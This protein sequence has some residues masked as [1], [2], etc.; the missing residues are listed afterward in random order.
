MFQNYLKV[1]WRNLTK[2]KV[3]FVINTLGLATGMAACGLILLY[4]T[5]ERSYDDFHPDIERTY[6]IELDSY[7][8]GKLAWRSATSYPAIAPTLQKDFPEVETTA[9]LYDAD[10]S[11]V[12]YENRRF[13]EA[14]FYFADSSI[15]K[16]L[17]IPF[18]KGNAATALQGPG[19]VV[20]SETTA[21]KY[22]GTADAMGKMLTLDRDPY[23]V[24]GV[25]RDYPANSHLQ[26]DLL[27]SYLTEP[28]AQTSWGWYDFYTYIKLRPGTNAR[29]FEA[30]IRD[31]VMQ[32]NGQQRK[33]ANIRN[34]VLLQP[35]RDIHLT[36]HLNQEAEVNGNG[37]AVTV[38][39]LIA[40]LILAIA[41]INYINLATARAVDRAKEV[42][43][44][45]T[46]GAGRGQLVGQFLFESFLLNGIAAGLALV[47]VWVSLPAFGMLTGRPLSPDGWLQHN[48]W[49]A[50]VGVFAVGTVLASLYPAFVLSNFRPVVV[51]K[52][53]VQ[54]V[55]GGLSLR[56][57]LIVIQFVA[58]IVLIVGTLTV[59]RQLRYMQEQDLGFDPEQTLVV[60]G[61]GVTDSTYEAKAA[62]FKQELLR[63][64]IVTKATA[65]A[66]VPGIEILWTRGCK[67][68]DRAEQ[69]INTMYNTSV[70]Y[71]FLNAYDIKL[72]AGRNF[73]RQFGTDSSG[74]LLNE[75]AVKLLDFGSPEDALNKQIQSGDTLRVVGVVKD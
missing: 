4:V 53:R 16:V 8:N 5:Y 52:G 70:D 45:K 31:L 24:R 44:R 48:R 30:K 21:R 1:A 65:S 10:N 59:Y 56:Q 33:A 68:I 34:E 29:L 23:Q 64:G 66:Y 72:V 75:T 18:V 32:H 20:I 12:A 27:F 2:S 67:R 6:R 57:T 47:I 22:F 71:E 26:L 43:I 39:S 35:V 25:F 14:N 13:R 55:A 61:A 62:A 46:V 69:A 3:F 7:Q 28:D 63:E 54:Q 49:Q 38:L 51:L 17:H 15:F 37:R 19:G 73:S 42:G 40:F 9:R 41:W 60:R 50:V 74:V 58:S 36:S 11:V